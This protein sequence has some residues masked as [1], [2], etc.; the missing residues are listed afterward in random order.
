MNKRRL[1]TGVI[2][3]GV[4]VIIAA[5]LPLTQTKANHCH[6]SHSQTPKTDVKK[7]VRTKASNLERQLG[8]ERKAKL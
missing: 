7:P 5:S 1:A 2:V 8:I 6:P 3:I 4:A